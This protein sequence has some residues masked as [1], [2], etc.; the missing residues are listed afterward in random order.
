LREEFELVLF[1]FNPNIFPENEYDKRLEEVRKIANQFGL[2]LI[3]GDYDHQ[4]WLRAIKGRE[5]DAEGGER[6]FICYRYRLEETVK[7]AKERKFDL[8]STTLTV[9]PHKKV[10]AIN[11]AGNELAIK[12]DIAFLERDFKKQDG[13]KKSSILSRELG[14]YRQNYCGCEFSRR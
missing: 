1:Y 5:L 8:F 3:I 14:L 9:S 10:L 2:D 11:N 13:F 4:A 7:I 12:Y 6:C